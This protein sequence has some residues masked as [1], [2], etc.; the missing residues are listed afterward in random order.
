MAQ[1]AQGLYRRQRH[2]AVALGQDVDAPPGVNGTGQ[3]PGVRGIQG[4][5][6]FGQVKPT[7]ESVENGRS[8]QNTWIDMDLYR[9]IIHNDL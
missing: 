5:E 4:R 9:F 7:W 3:L 2:P 1:E 6:V 8:D